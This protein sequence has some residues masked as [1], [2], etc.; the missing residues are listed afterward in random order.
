MMA[1]EWDESENL[2]PSIA[3]SSPSSPH[4]P[5]PSTAHGMMHR[6]CITEPERNP[7]DA[8]SIR[9]HPYY[10]VLSGLHVHS[11]FLCIGSAPTSP[12]LRCSK[13]DFRPSSRES[14]QTRSPPW[15]CPSRPMLSVNN[16]E[17]PAY[18]KQDPKET[19]SMF[20]SQIPYVRDETSLC[21]PHSTIPCRSRTLPRPLR[22]P[23]Y[24][25]HR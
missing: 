13:R 4:Q 22:C 19:R 14:R 17:C 5:R 6:R 18:R 16:Q 1:P 20:P 23:A 2:C 15:R 21:N 7:T 9:F 24:D 11:P 10:S 8:T 3:H 12:V 25:C